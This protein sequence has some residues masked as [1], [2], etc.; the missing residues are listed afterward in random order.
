MQP[1][2]RRDTSRPVRPSFTY[3][4]VQL[5]LKVRNESGKAPMLGFAFGKI[6][7]EDALGSI[8]SYFGDVSR[9]ASGYRGLRSRSAPCQLQT[10]PDQS[11]AAGDIYS[12]DLVRCTSA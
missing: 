7:G 6:N 9:P 12:G 1:R 11:G 8:A 3:S 2:H 10:L 5:L 4:I